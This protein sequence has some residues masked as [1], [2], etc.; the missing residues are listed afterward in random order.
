M[1]TQITLFF[2]R[3]CLQTPHI[4]VIFI[5]SGPSLTKLQTMKTAKMIVL[6]ILTMVFFSFSNTTDGW[7]S[8]FDGETLEGWTASEHTDAWKIVDGAIVTGGERSHL[9]Y[10]GDVLDHNFLNFEY[11]VDVMTQPNSNSGIY[12]HTEFQEEGWPAKGYECQVLNSTIP[13]DYVEH[14]LSGSI[15]AVDEKFDLFDFG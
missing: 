10:S 2:L 6:A 4:I 8:L 3:S 11:S 12:I 7:I 13:G 15:Y 9:F 14:K 1:K 5:F